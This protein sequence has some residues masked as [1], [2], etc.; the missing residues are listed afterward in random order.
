[1][2][3]RTRDEAGVLDSLREGRTVVY[4]RERAYGDPAL[5]RLAEESGGLPRDVPDLP[6]PGVL[7]V[8]SRLA[9]V[10]ALLGAVLLR[11]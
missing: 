2:F 10:L 8:F 11:K 1:V 7:S 5:I 4:D 3:A 6:P 9:C